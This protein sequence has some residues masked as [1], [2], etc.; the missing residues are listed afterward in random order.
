MSL[1]ILDGRNHILFILTQHDSLIAM[2]GF[3]AEHSS[4]SYLNKVVGASAD[5][6][7]STNYVRQILP[8]KFGFW[9]YAS[10]KSG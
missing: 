6:V 1:H 4:S 10:R 3:D 7:R 2:S 8:N 5:L 9:I